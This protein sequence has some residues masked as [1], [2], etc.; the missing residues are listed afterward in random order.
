[1]KKRNL[2]LL[3]V[4]ALLLCIPALA[5]AYENNSTCPQAI[6]MEGRLDGVKDAPVYAEADKKSP[7]LFRM[8]K[9]DVCEVTGRFSGYY[10][11]EL[12]GDAGYISKSL[13]VLCPF[14]YRIIVG[15]DTVCLT[16]IFAHSIVHSSSR[17]NYLRII[18]MTL[19]TLC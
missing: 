14:A 16:N 4:L 7:V 15:K 10:R 5:C 3:A 6:K 18:S 17:K 2:L 19:S 11:I 9:G 12:N 13:L 1:M 8:E